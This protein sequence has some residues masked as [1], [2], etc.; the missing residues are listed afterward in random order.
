MKYLTFF[1]TPLLLAMNASSAELILGEG[2]KSAYQ[3][4][5]P[6]ESLSPEVDASL[7][8]TARLLQ[9]A[10]QANGIA[11][12]VVR[13][14]EANGAPGI[15]LGDTAFA[16]QQGIDVTKLNGWGYIHRVVGK[17]DLILAG[18][19]HP[20]PA[21]PDN[22]RRPGWDRIGTAKA[23]ADFLRE[24]V[25]VR[26]LFPEMGPH[27]LL[28][29]AATVDLL[30]TAAIEYLPTSPVAVSDD[31]D[32]QHTPAIEY[33]ITYPQ[34][35]SF[36]DLANNRFPQV[37]AF[38]RGH[39]WES[40]VPK[41]TYRET[42]P[43]YFALVGGKRRLEGNGQYCLSNPD[44]QRLIYE[45][46]AGQLDKG[47]ASVD[48]GQPDG[49]RA[50]QCD[51]CEALYDTGDNW[52]EKIW[53]FN[54]TMAQALLKS[55]PD[56]TIMMMS[57]I[58]TAKP[59]ETFR[60]FPSNTRI[61]LTGTNEE[62]IAPWRG[63]EVP[64]GFTGYLYNWCPNLGTRYT[65]MRTPLFVETQ[66]KRLHKNRIQGFRRDGPGA[67]YG[68][69]G[70]VYYTM[71]RMYDDPENLSAA[72]L[73]PEFV[74]GAFKESA[75]HMTRFYE[76]LY[77][78]IVLYSDEIGTRCPTWTYQPMKGRRRKTVQDP[79][80]MITFLYP[81]KV[82][83]DL[84]S[85]LA[86]AETKA[87]DPKVKQRLA[88][89]RRE[90]DYVRHFARVAHLHQAYEVQPDLASRD[91]LLDAIDARNAEIANYYGHRD[92]PTP[93]S[94]GWSWVMFP[95][96]GHNAA[97]L[98]LAHNLYQGPYQDTC[99]NWDT[100]AMRAAPLPGAKQLQVTQSGG[101]SPMQL[102]DAAW[103][104][105]E[106]HSLKLG[107]G[108]FRVL[109]DASRIYVRVDAPKAET[110]TDVF[111]VYLQPTPGSH[112]A[113]RFRTGPDSSRKEG[114]A[115]GFI[116]DVMDPRYG[117]FDRDWKGDWECETRADAATGRWQ[118]LFS[119]PF[120]T[121]S[122]TAPEA[123]SFWRA[124]VVRITAEGSS[125]WSDAAGLGS[126]DDRNAFGEWTFGTAKE[127][128]ERK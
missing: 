81:P 22:P 33:N 12:A 4:I 67:L 41:E 1:L 27:R 58:L 19:D 88:V 123:G 126:P 85:L 95:P 17:R 70:P 78:T 11:I 102:A 87:R 49:F 103:E 118:A 39:T 107:N 32:V 104:K 108:E 68:L 20:A 124:N 109:A 43:E 16:R 122:A 72:K 83:A 121:V 73:V 100:A 24:H 125:A 5:L 99:F 98:R 64:G 42:H 63:H 61:M 51:D 115:A 46:L 119:I 112:H 111:A 48:L 36:Y 54:R 6:D 113:W 59:P 29:R 116:A 47:F 8:Q 75:W 10:F 15:F 94:E 56:K 128:P 65:P 34:G 38:H 69:E 84:E 35:G 92:R 13:E 105:A 53:I 18:H 71:G 62:D 77:Q 30:N 114:A 57:Y 74:E 60:K 86:A 52:G 23:V 127:S 117:Q 101:N 96:A 97:H 3:I 45:D 93:V 14:T 40:A 91:R 28:P 7:V 9:T 106:S 55:H 90:F 31:L 82:L 25:G 110:A 2:E 89:V 21:K 44:V 79:F 37:D 76:R 120:K 50:C 80:R 66:A 26:F